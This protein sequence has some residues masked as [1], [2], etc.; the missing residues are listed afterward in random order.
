MCNIVSPYIYI[1]YNDSN[2]ELINPKLTCCV[3]ERTR[4]IEARIIRSG[5]RDFWLVLVSIMAVCRV[6]SY[7]PLTVVL[8]WSLV[9]GLSSHNGHNASQKHHYQ[10]LY[11]SVITTAI[12]DHR[13]VDRCPK[14]ICKNTYFSFVVVKIVQDVV[15]STNKVNV[16]CNFIFR[17]KVLLNFTSLY[18]GIH[19][20]NVSW[21]KFTSL[22]LKLKY[23]IR[24][25]GVEGR[26]SG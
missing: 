11:L 16:I 7:A 23:H 13:K 17:R 19:N 18:F 10:Y 21:T 22:K 3:L 25:G 8:P 2:K 5:V 9:R 20:L 1:T 12:S 26:G 14:N 6:V 24:K 4:S 15:T